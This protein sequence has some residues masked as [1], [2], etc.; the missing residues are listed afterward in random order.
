VAE[1]AYAYVTLIPVAKGFQKAVA[2]EM[3][4]VGKVGEKAGDEAGKGVSKGFGRSIAGIAGLIAGAFSI[5]AITNFAKE[6]VAAAEAVS[7]ANARID[8]VAKSTG[9]FG[10]ETDAVTKR[11]QDFAKA[12]EMRIAVDDTVIKGVQAQLLTFKELSSTADE[13]G[14]VFDRVTMAAFDMAQVV[15]SAEGN[16]TALGK[17]LEDP[18]RG[19]AALARN[20]TTFTDQQREQIKVLQESGDL[21]GAQEIILQEVESQY[22]GLAEASADASVKLGLAFGNIKETVGD[23]LL[24]IFADLVDGMLPVIDELANTL[25]VV[26]QD[27]SPIISELAG[28]LPGLIQSFLPMLPVIGELAGIFLGLVERFLP[29]FVD[30]ILSLMPAFTELVPVIADFIANALDILVPILLDLV[31]AIIPIVQALLPVFM[32]LVTA[33]APIVIKL[34]EAFLPLIM[35]VLPILIRL[36]EFLAPIFIG[37]ASIIG[38][39]IVGAIGLLVGAIS[40]VSDNLGEFGDFFKTLWNGIKTF[41]GS[42]INGLIGGFEGFVNGAV[43]GINRVIDAINSMAF[44]VPDWVPEIGGSRFGFNIG[45]LSEISLPRVALAEGG[46]VDRPTNAL[47]GEAGPEVVMPLDRFERVMGIGDGP[48]QAVNYYAAPNKSFDAEQELQLA[49][50]RVRMMA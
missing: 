14:G 37:I 48:G 49:M 31:A 27:L 28:Q 6:S 40:W 38:N 33:L 17:A 32:E 3:G 46:M 36:I 24:P 25:A 16:A 35:M 47:I 4:G 30:L 5:R 9:V 43:R 45:R 26:F 18:T 44:T 10:A 34:I 12:Q 50:R 41:F 11:I 39:V 15:G 21:L 7:T 19:V 22:G 1:Q 42:I 13:T 8:Q 29:I 2:N 23:V 20:G